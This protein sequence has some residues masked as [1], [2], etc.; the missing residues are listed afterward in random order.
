MHAFRTPWIDPWGGI[1]VTIMSIPLFFPPTKYESGLR[2]TGAM[3]LSEVCLAAGVRCAATGAWT[4]RKVEIAHGDALSVFAEPGDWGGVK[5]ILKPGLTCQQEA[6]LA[7]AVMAY[8]LHDLVA[9]QSIA[10]KGWASVAAPRGRPPS[11]RPLTAAD[12]QRAFRS[13][14]K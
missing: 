4:A 13:R 14:R 6:R 2:L 10:G 9:K 8:S 7:L 3:S 11:A 12:R 1:R 5:I